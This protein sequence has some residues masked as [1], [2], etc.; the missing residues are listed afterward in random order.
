MRSYYMNAAGLGPEP[1][2]VLA[3]HFL[4][5]GEA[6]GLSVHPLFEPEHYRVTYLGGSVGV[7]PVIDYI[8]QGHGPR[9]PNPLFDQEFY[10][11][12]AGG[13]IDA[14]TV[15]LVHYYQHGW[16]EGL[17]P[18][19]LFSVRHYLDLYDDVRRLGY[20]PLQHYIFDGAREGRS[21]CEVF[22]G[23]FYTSSYADVQSSGINPLTHFVKHGWA[24]GR[25]PSAD[26]DA[27]WYRGW[28]QGDADA[29]LYPNPLAHYYRVG[30]ARG[31]PR[32]AANLVLDDGGSAPR[33][34]F[35]VWA[36]G[37]LAAYRSAMPAGP[38]GAFLVVGAEPPSEGGGIDFGDLRRWLS[39]APVH[40]EPLLVFL[41]AEDELAAGVEEILAHARRAEGAAPFGSSLFTLDSFSLEGDVA[42]PYLLPGRNR[43][44]LLEAP[45]VPP[46]CADAGLCR[47][48]PPRKSEGLRAWFHRLVEAAAALGSKGLGH[49]PVPGV[50]VPAERHGGGAC[51]A[52]VADLA[53]HVACGGGAQRGPVVSVVICTKDCGHLLTQLVIDL[54]R[55]DTDGVREVILVLNRP[56]NG[57]AV[58]YHERLARLPK[59][60][61]VVYDREYNFSDQCNEGARHATGEFLLFLNDDIVPVGDRW[62]SQ[63]LS[64]LADERV[65]VVGPLLLYPD[66]RVQHAGMYLGFNAVCGHSLR[67]AKLPRA[68]SMAG[69]V[70]SNCSAVT[71]AV[72]LVR[73]DLFRSLGGFDY[74]LGTYLQDLDFCL[75]VL[76]MGGEIVYEPAAILFHMESVS[77]TSTFRDP[78]I[79]ARRGREHERF[80]RR[81]HAMMKLDRH[82]N[83][84][85][86][87][88]DE[89]LR[90]LAAA[91]PARFRPLID[92]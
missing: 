54:V 42:R 81:W 89:S 65:G 32:T 58:A 24:E 23:A 57:F 44:Y 78:A 80:T 37:V 56:E 1:D 60:R 10:L 46:F 71:G 76:R 6:A 27:G 91:Q 49:V 88:Q 30:R 18:A 59:V 85:W 77:A 79:L 33:G 70:A 90:T 66:E 38:S 61:I 55:P 19:P 43:V 53:E 83:V 25:L 13:T 7:S 67:G 22:D 51:R 69:L 40:P 17:D 39:S 68:G 14:G 72:M 8:R 29:A 45:V 62:L 87:I 36:S 28:M 21:P 92:G 52:V 50:I 84:N 64:Q 47:A 5:R 2:A 82:H 48:H 3:R 75:R 12:Q 15:P 86:S 34:A 26:F 63:M 4:E 74:S 35:E 73:A 11:R 20:E 16:R 9:G 31:Y 41:Q